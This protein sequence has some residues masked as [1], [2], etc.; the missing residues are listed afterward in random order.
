MLARRC[1]L[2]IMSALL[3]GTT[4]SPTDAAV[5]Q[6]NRSVVTRGGVASRHRF[7]AECRRRQRAR[8]NR[9]TLAGGAG[10]AVVGAAAM[11]TPIGA[12]LGAIAGHEIAKHRQRC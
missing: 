10:G 4:S 2:V 9:G 3:A 6:P 5:V 7:A 11:A 1:V 12:G 8:A